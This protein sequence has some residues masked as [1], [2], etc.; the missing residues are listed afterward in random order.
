MLDQASSADALPDSRDLA[1]CFNLFLGRMPA[2]TLAD[3]PGSTSLPAVLRHIFET[4]EFKSGILQAVLLRETL[5]HEKLAN[6]AL[7]PLIDWVQNRLPIDASTR[8][9]AGVARSWAQLLE[10]LLADAKLI[11][12]APELAAVEVDRILRNRLENEPISKVKRSVFGVVDAASGFGVRGWAMDLCSKS[13]PVILELYA[14]NTFL[15]AVS[16][17]EPRPDVHDVF[18]G[19]GKCGFS[20]KISPAHRESF[21]AGRTLFAVDSVS[22]EPVGASTKVYADAVQNFDAIEA[23]RS[24]LA[25]L[26]QILDRIEEQLPEVG[27][28]SSV[29]IEAY[30]EYWYRFYK[31]TPDILREQSTRSSGFAYRPLISVVLP[32]RNS[33]AALLHKAIQSVLGQTYPQWELIISDDASGHDELTSVQLSYAADKRIRWIEGPACEGIAANT[34]RA[35]AASSGDYIAFLDHDDELAPDALYHVAASLQ[36]YR[37]CLLYSDEDRIEEDEFGQPI[38]HTPFFKP[39][40]DPDLLLSINYICHLVVFRRD[41]LTALGGL[42]TGFEGA[43]DHDL[44][45]RAVSSL[46]PR[47]IRHLP[48]VLYHWRVTPGSVSRTPGLSDQI[49]NNIEA[50]VKDHL[51]RLNVAAEVEPHSEPLGSARQYA[52]RVRWPLPASPPKI[53][54]ILPTRDRVDLLR[55]CVRSLI[56]SL[57]TYP[58]EYE[59]L[60]IDNDSCERETLDYLSNLNTEPSIRLIRFRGPFNYSAINNA[61]ARAASGQVLVFLNNDTLVLTKDW[62]VELV[63]HAMREDVGAVGA[64]LLYSDGTIQ[65][66]GVLLGV[67]GIAGHE[68][69][70]DNPRSD[71]YF[72]RSRLLRSAAAVT[73]AC[74]A[75]RRAIFLELDGGFDELSLKVAFNDV[76]YCIRVRKAGYRVVYNPFAVLYHFESKSRGREISEEQRKRHRAEAAAFYLRWKA[77]DIFDPYYNLHFERFAR[78]FERLRPPPDI[79]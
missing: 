2:N 71:G 53:S 29:P 66:A 52:T 75:T 43:Q 31:L 18:G 54:I 44:L 65:H 19:D 78:P 9:A 25:Q 28:M 6:V 13:A 41:I 24:E 64:R 22:R 62:C 74:L 35:I 17:D 15:G 70:G 42:R 45:L 37:Y 57:R 11:A 33:D 49:Q 48:R 14:D 55:P 40:F 30:N 23:M 20:F 8:C 51:R 69:V 79:H 34:N 16:C 4:Q 77:A 36:D 67:E 32:I 60:L 38:H 26:R 3:H 56:D 1:N 76:D 47:D 63:A 59:I 50:A 46:S 10:L 68:C 7:L 27:R 12:F 58:G 72:G 61:G 5:P 73:G 39:G 21:G